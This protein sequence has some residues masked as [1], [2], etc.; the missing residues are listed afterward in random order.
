M[1]RL[2]VS[3]ISLAL[4]TVPVSAQVKRLKCEFTNGTPPKLIIID[5]GAKTLTYESIDEA[6]NI[7]PVTGGLAA[8]LA[9]L[10]ADITSETI[11]ARSQRRCG[12][13]TAA[14]NRRSGS[15]VLTFCAS[16]SVSKPCVPYTVGPQKF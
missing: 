3:A 15:L 8:G 1:K 12:M 16:P 5:Y 9:N 4:M 2:A 7:D 14:L 10:P 11:S 6:G 13:F